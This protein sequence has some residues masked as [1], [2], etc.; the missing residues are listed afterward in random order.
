MD[1]AHPANGARLNPLARQP[2]T[3]PRVPIVAH[4]RDQA[5]FA[6]NARH[7]PRFLDGARHCLLNI[8]SL[9]ARNAAKVMGACMWSGVAIMTA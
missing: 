8:D 1:F 7:D 9:P 6:G 3:F 5:G 2:Q 4:L